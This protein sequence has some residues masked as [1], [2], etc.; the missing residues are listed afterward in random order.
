MTDAGHVAARGITIKDV[1]AAAGVHPSTVSRS[2]DPLQ[3]SRVREE[4]RQRVLEAA[5]ELNYRPDVWARGLRQQRTSTIGVLVPDFGNPIHAE[6]I[7]GINL[8]LERDG[9]TAVLLET[10]DRHERFQSGLR[11]L[12]DRRV[13][14][15]ISAATRAGDA[16]ALRQVVRS[17]VPVVMA[18]RWIRGLDVPVVANDDLRGGGLA[19]QHL[20]E[21]GHHRLAQLHGPTDIETFNERGLGFRS[22]LARA[23]LPDAEPVGYAASPTV[24]EGRRLMRALLATGDRPTA[25]FAHNDLMA[26]G[27]MEALAEA[28]LRVPHDVSVVGYNDMPLTEHLAPPLTT[29]RMPI[30]DVGRVAAETALGLVR[31]T[32]VAAELAISLQPRLVV[33]SSAAPPAPPSPRAHRS[34][35]RPGSPAAPSAADRRSE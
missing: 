1:A 12:T 7:R 9:Y 22:A 6:L 30:A 34:V 31:H 23:G 35:K 20:V 18:V 3:A 32:A 21:I 24:A 13:D 19:A 29:V 11:L 14:A 8:R 25:V 17:G 27:A 16:R 33:R 10:C 5:S 2:M 4:T 26:I 15:V 28:S